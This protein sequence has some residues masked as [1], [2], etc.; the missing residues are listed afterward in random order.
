MEA[1]RACKR[2]TG[3]LEV[4][5]GKAV[6]LTLHL[7]RGHCT[8][9]PIFQEWK[10]NQGKSGDESRVTG[11]A[12]RQ[13][14]NCSWLWEQFLALVGVYPTPLLLTQLGP[15][16]TKDCLPGPPYWGTICLCPP[17]HLPRQGPSSPAGAPRHCWPP[18]GSGPLKPH[19]RHSVA[20]CSP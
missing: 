1:P 3:E 13:N 10:Q 6:G 2:D 20:C 4:L 8:F 9:N 17:P 16:S 19:L 15:S 12:S 5:G 18:L 14:Q 11:L 7:P